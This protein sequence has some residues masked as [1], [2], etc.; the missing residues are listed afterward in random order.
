MATMAAAIA[1]EVLFLRLGYFRIVPWETL[2]LV[3]VS[4]ALAFVGWRRRRGPARA[5]WLVAACALAAFF[6]WASFVL[7]R[8][9][10][11]TPA[12]ERLAFHALD[13]EGARVELPAAMQRKFALV[14]LFRGAW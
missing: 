2:P 10:E 9:P 4:L 12:P 11:R 7:P 6:V 5:S 14:V 3:A 1:L 13:L 8:L